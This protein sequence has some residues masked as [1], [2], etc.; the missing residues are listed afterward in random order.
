MSE[1]QPWRAHYPAGVPHEI[2]LEYAS[3]SDYITQHC[4][5]YAELPA[6]TLLGHSLNYAQVA[7]KSEL[8]AR[9]LQQ[10]CQ[11]V[12]GDRVAIMLPNVLQYPIALFGILR[13]GLVVVNINPLYTPRELT[14]Q[15]TDAGVQAILVLA[16]FAHVVQQALT[17]VKVPHVI[18]TDFGD[19]LPIIKR[20]MVNTVLRLRGKVPRWKIAHALPWHQALGSAAKCELN[21]VTIGHEDLAFLQYT[22]GTT[23]TPKGAMLTHGNMLA[24]LAQARAWVAS[25]L[26]EREECIVTA[27]PF[28]HIFA[29]LA[30]CLLFVGLGAN[31]ILIPNARDIA[32]MIKALRGVPFTAITGV[33]T[34]YNALLHHPGFAELDFSHFKLALSGAMALSKPVF[35]AWQVLTG[36]SIVVAYGLTETSPA[37]AINPLD[38]QEN[39]PGR[40]GLPLSSTEVAIRDEQGTDL[41]CNEVGELWVKGP[42]VMVGYWQNPQETARVLQHGWLATGDLAYLDPQGYLYIVDRKKDMIK[43]SGFCVYPNEVEQV[44]LNHPAVLEVGVIGEPDNESGERVKAFVVVD[45]PVDAQELRRYAKKY[46]TAYKVPKVIEFRD[47][48]PKT[49][50]GKILRRELR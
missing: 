15:L 17:Q 21:P 23:G 46:L 48:L 38:S 41:P 29:L 25:T 8:F 19:E 22:G 3:L 40:V 24:N 32:S 28:Y 11:L 42:Q 9:F 37:V 7:H 20:Y 16:N 13:A 45:T 18:V 39:I 27:L 34:L 2:Q 36:V 33:N 44:L 12:K 14:E 4:Q 35:N 49:N 43:V 50:V 30:N 47:Q 31:N 5:R 1:N 10:K 26:Q 6:Y